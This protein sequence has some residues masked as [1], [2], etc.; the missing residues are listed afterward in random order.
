ML[1]ARSS[2]VEHK[3]GSVLNAAA[4]ERDAAPRCGGCSLLDS[5]PST[6][7]HEAD[8]DAPTDAEL[9]PAVGPPRSPIAQRRRRD[10]SESGGCGR[11]AV[12]PASAAVLCTEDPQC[13]TSSPCSV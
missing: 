13:A 1:T 2:G 7:P 3:S 6:A 11:H 12:A 8:R 10:E 4:H 9:P 5:P